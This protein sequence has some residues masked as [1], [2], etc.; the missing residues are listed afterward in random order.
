[1]WSRTDSGI[2]GRRGKWPSRSK[3]LA[4]LVARSDQPDGSVHRA[5]RTSSCRLAEKAMLLSQVEMIRLRRS[6][7]IHRVGRVPGKL[8][9]LWM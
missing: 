7:P 2:G 1:M 3:Q 5:D 8:G 6:E 9:R 4:G